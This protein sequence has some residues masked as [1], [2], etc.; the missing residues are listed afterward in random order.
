MCGR[1]TQTFDLDALRMLFDLDEIDAEVNARYNIAPTQSAPVIFEEDGARRMTLMRWGLVPSWAKD[2]S[3]GNKMIN[4]RAETLAEKPSFRTALK[5]RRCIIPA[6]SFFEWYQPKG[7][8]KKVPV[9]AVLKDRSLFGMAGLWEVWKQP[10]G[11]WLRTYTIITGEPN[12]LLKQYHH[13]MAVILPKE[14]IADWLNPDNDD[15]SA[16]LDLLK[17]YPADQ[18]EVY[19][20]ST[21]VNSP[22]NDR[23]EIV[24]PQGDLFG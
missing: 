9:R 7:A 17:P 20:V 22:T 14:K 18:M 2:P 10:D 11:E 24:E 6:D 5:K 13:R 8:K 4:A 23:P 1:Y 16:L 15:Q 12:S 19:T 21:L 3:I